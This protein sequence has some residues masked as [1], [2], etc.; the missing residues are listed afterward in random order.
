[1]AAPHAVGVAALIRAAHPGM[2]PAAVAAALRAGATTMPC[3]TALD[4]GV[5]FFEA[6]VQV[7]KGGQGSNNFY[8]AGLVNAIAASR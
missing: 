5:E 3:P 8:G 7:C 4:P 1:M 6:P 2:P